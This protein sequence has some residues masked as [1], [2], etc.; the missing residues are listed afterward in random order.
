MIVY[1]DGEFV[2]EERAV[3]SVNDRGLLFGDAV[4]E[5]GL[6]RN[7]GFFRLHQHLQ[8]FVASAALLQLA[9]P[10]PAEL[11]ALVHRLARANHMLDGNLRITLTRGVRAPCLIIAIRPLDPVWTERARRGW[12]I[13]TARTRRPSIAAAP[14]QLKAVGRTY[15][16]LARMEAAAAGV[17]DALLLT[18]HDMVCE[19]PAWNVF[20][21]RRDALFTPATDAG[22][23]AGVTRSAVLDLADSTGFRV[24]EGLFPRTDLDDADEVFATMTSVGIVSIR[25]LDRRTLPHDTPAADALQPRYWAVVDAECAADRDP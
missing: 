12:S 3:V 5:T 21:R 2:D 11:A 20:W 6:L 18:D 9:H 17:D 22:V 25:R 8:R 16:L 14:P 10:A 4:F 7:G 24:R 13:I 23:L 15:A 19:G 1:L